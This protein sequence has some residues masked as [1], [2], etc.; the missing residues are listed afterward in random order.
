MEHKNIKV[1]I[2]IPVYNVEKYLDKCIKSVLK[3]THENLEIIMVDD[4]STDNSGKIA[5]SYLDKDSRIK[6]IHKKN[7][8]VSVARNT[9]ID[10][11]TGEYVCFADADDYLLPD[12]VEYLLKLAVENDADVALT[13]DMFTTFHPN[14]VDGDQ[15][16]I[17]TPEQA[18]IDI[19]TY[20]LP[21]G[22]YCKIFKRE[23]LGKEIRFVPHIYI[24]E[25]FN[26]NTMAFQRA[27]KVVEGNR[28]VYFYRRDNPTSATTK[29]SLDKW[30]NAIYA[31]EN[32]HK[33]MIL[34]SDR[35]ETAW[36]Y[37]NWHTHCDAFNFLVMA[38]EKKEY[39]TVYKKWKKV[40]R[41]QAGFA[42][43]VDIIPREKI[44]AI[45]MIVWPQL[46]P[47]MINQRNK[48]YMCRYRS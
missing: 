44:R 10:A 40:V 38:K 17:K 31:I 14:Q 29:F 13:K 25:G 37:A 34:H 15:I 24:G 20:N 28:R 48:K 3:Q 33:D 22:V 2:V 27:N 41:T 6:V 11:A 42:F 9:G 18:T 47:W 45:I 21:I 26:F 23:F 43:K 39:K 1:S 36:N 35:L 30:E 32:I 12:Y 19:L 8:K 16:Q 5:D 46:M 7:E 4:G